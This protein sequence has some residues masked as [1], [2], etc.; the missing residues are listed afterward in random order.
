MDQEIGN[1]QAVGLTADIVSAYVGNNVVQ[2]SD[3][4]ALIADVHKALLAAM[5]PTLGQAVAP[6]QPQLTA[7]QIK[8]SITPD[9]LI[10]FE[11]GKKYKTLRRSLTLLGLTPPAYREKWGLPADYPVTAP[12]YSQQRSELARTLG[13]GRRR[14]G[15][16]MKVS[17]EGAL[18]VEAF[19][20]VAESAE[21]EAGRGDTA[22]LEVAAATEVTHPELKAKRVPPSRVK[23]S[24]VE[25]A[26]A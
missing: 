23:R 10:S 1:T 2:R 6:E 25:P 14:K 21:G 12:A 26:I 7:K 16:L 20:E 18:N 13:L 5:S 22:L 9:H 4:P 11:D 3:L 15:G 24:K 8:R 17:A 19:E